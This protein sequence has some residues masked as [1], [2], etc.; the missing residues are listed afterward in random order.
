[1]LAVFCYLTF[2]PQYNVWKISPH[3]SVFVTPVNITAFLPSA[4]L[5]I[6]TYVFDNALFYKS[7][8][9]NQAYIGLL[10]N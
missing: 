9:S 7:F 8:A 3:N 2:S 5:E 4:P 6:D 1:M 10:R